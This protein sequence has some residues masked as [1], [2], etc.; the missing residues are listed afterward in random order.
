MGD[1]RRRRRGRRRGAGRK[2]P[3]LLS[4]ILLDF[5]LSETD[6]LV[7]DWFPHG[8]SDNMTSQLSLLTEC[9]LWTKKVSLCKY[10]LF[11]A[12]FIKLGKKLFEHK[13]FFCV[14]STMRK[15][16]GSLNG[17]CST[18]WLLVFCAW[19]VVYRWEHFK[20]HVQFWPNGHIKCWWE[21]LYLNSHPDQWT[22]RNQVSCS[23]Q[24]VFTLTSH[25]GATFDHHD[26]VIIKKC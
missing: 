5:S 20:L 18:N 16:S 26:W 4:Y 21:H 8:K 22:Y 13:Y 10:I 15:W 25:T 17:Q 19:W 14:V 6:L 2:T 11:K 3:Q 9:P 7:S 24:P 23:S 12:I 1:G